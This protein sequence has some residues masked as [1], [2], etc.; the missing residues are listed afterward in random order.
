MNKYIYILIEESNK[1]HCLVITGCRKAAATF[2][3]QC[4]SNKL[5]IDLCFLTS[6][7]RDLALVLLVMVS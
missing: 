6:A 4:Y 5:K 7:K 3:L 2:V 1:M